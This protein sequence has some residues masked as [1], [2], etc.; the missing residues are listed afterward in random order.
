[1]R[2]AILSLTLLILG[3]GGGEQDAGDEE[4][5]FGYDLVDVDAPAPSAAV[6]SE[7]TVEAVRRCIDALP[8]H[9]GVVLALRELEGLPCTEIAR[10]VDATHVTVRWRLHRARKL[11]LEEWERQSRRSTL[12]Q[13]DSPQTHERSDDAR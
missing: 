4:T 10:I 6:E 9:F 11:F 8:P 1:M 5:D 12:E 3:C 7:E 2:Y 13:L